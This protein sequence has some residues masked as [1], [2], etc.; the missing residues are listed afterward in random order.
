MSRFVGANLLD[1][2]HDAEEKSTD[3]DLLFSFLKHMPGTA[4]EV[5]RYLKV[6]SASE[7]HRFA[8]IKIGGA[9]VE[10][11]LEELAKQIAF[12]HRVGLVPTIVHGGGPQL[13]LALERA[14]I[15]HEF[16]DGLRVST[17]QVMEHALPVFERQNTMLVDALEA[18]GVRARPILSGVF[19]AKLL[20]RAKYG[21]VGDVTKAKTDIILRSIRANAV[22]IVAS[23]GQTLSGMA[24]NINA[25]IAASSLAKELKP[26]KTVYLNSMGGL[27]DQEDKQI[28]IISMAEDFSFYMSQSWFRHGSRLKLREIRDLLL[29]LPSDSTVC[30]TKAGDLLKELFT[31]GGGGTMFLRGTPW[32]RAEGPEEINKLDWEKL[33]RVIAQGFGRPLVEGYKE[34]LLESSDDIRIYYT[35]GYTAAAIIKFL[36]GI[37]VPY[38]DKFVVDPRFRRL[39]LAD[40]LMARITADYDKMFWRSR[41]ENPINGFY[42]SVSDGTFSDDIW[43]VFWFGTLSVDEVTPLIKVAVTSSE[44]LEKMSTPATED[45]PAVPAFIPRLSTSTPRVGIVGAR[46]FTG[47]ELMKLIIKHP[48]M[49]LACVS[50]RQLSGKRISSNLNGMFPGSDAGC[51]MDLRYVNMEADQIEE[52]TRV[53]GIDAWVMALP[54]G[55]CLPF[56]EALGDTPVTVVD[57]GADF[58][59]NDK[60]AYGMPEINRDAIRQSKRIANPGCYATGAQMAMIPFANYLAPNIATNVFGV[61]GYSGAGTNPSEKNDPDVLRDNMIPYALQGHIHEREIGHH[62]HAPV[63]FMPHV[64]PH[65]QGIQ[66]T[67]SMTLASPLASAEEAFE[68]AQKRF[69]ND[70]LIRVQKEP[71]RVRDN[72][73]RHHVSVGGYTLDKDKVRL[74][75]CSTIDNLLKGAATQCLQN[76]NLSLGLE[77]ELSG[78]RERVAEDDA[79]VETFPHAKKLPTMTFDEAVEKDQEFVTNTYGK[80]QALL[81][82]GVGSRVYDD[83]SGKSYVD[84]VAGI[85]VNVFGHSDPEWA[86]V[87]A[88]QAER[89]SHTSNLYYT[90]EQVQLAEKL[91]KSTWWGTKT[92]FANTGTEANEAAIKFSRKRGVAISPKKTKVVSFKKGFHGRTM[93]S[94]SVTEKKAYREQFGSM[95]DFG[96]DGER[97]VALNDKKAFDAAMSDDVCAV[98]VEPLQGEGGVNSA[99]PGFLRYI[100]QQC[101][102]YGALMIV[103]EVQCGLGRTGTV[104]AHEIAFP[105]PDSDQDPSKATCGDSCET[106]CEPCQGPATFEACDSC[107][108]VCAR[109]AAPDIMSVAKPIAGGLAMGLV[110]C[111]EE[112]TSHLVP[113]DHGTTF[114]GS[115]LTCA[116]ALHVLERVANPEFL[117]GVDLAGQHMRERLRN[118][119]GVKNVR[120][121]GLINGFDIHPNLASADVVLNCRDHGLFVHSAGPNTIRL[122]P[123]L[124]VRLDEM[125]E[126]LD[127]L[128]SVLTQYKD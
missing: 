94:L 1:L 79:R 105:A 42:R 101:T 81:H 44:T 25:D 76:L 58:R 85:A 91:V 77:D 22:P 47:N 117:K 3:Q 126:G 64:A 100:R 106:V 127:I 66:L 75:A 104:W 102:K 27:M 124:N 96:K 19:E 29:E 6:F 108:T 83:N 82:R 40:Q 39:G 88:R 110:I 71:P 45:T 5:S 31:M 23:I 50:S 38:L 33:E 95:V 111:N 18:R 16:V 57:L 68:I 4:R 89:L 109:C 122:I 62:Q 56:V 54:N 53:N 90:E 128:A 115:P 103:D 43:R 107:T 59:F 2:F 7:K 70:P 41:E 15:V 74:V 8:V 65:F 60:W 87:I 69:V 32:R 63:R 9:V 98:I 72:S 51:G 67:V 30:I 49:E 114:G 21:L 24:L 120:G 46:G 97:F 34:Q 37:D 28:P 99:G 92:F 52:Y 113:G 12:L 26:L 11:N 123:A 80:R 93:G 125:D 17:E 35:E 48:N 20:D 10:E 55:V 84:L 116:A 86:A 13:N 121:R 14:G 73:R 119:D 36:P 112:A 78:I 61:S 118:M